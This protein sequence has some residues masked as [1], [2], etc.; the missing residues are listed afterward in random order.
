MSNVRFVYPFDTPPAAE[1]PQ[2]LLGGKGAG[3]S[4]MTQLGIQ[5]PH[6]FTITTEMCSHYYESREHIAES[7][8]QEVL[9][10]IVRLE[11]RMNKRFGD[12]QD[13]LLVSVR[14]GA[15]VSMPGMMDTILNLGLN[16]QTV[17]GLAQ[18]SGNAFF[19]WDSYQRF[20]QMYAHVVLGIKLSA[21]S[22]LYNAEGFSDFGSE[23]YQN[24]HLDETTVSNEPDQVKVIAERVEDMKDEVLQ[25]TGRPFPQDVMEQL[26]GGIEAVLKSWHSERAV[27]YRRHHRYPDDWGTAVNVQAMVFGN[28]GPTSATGVAFTRDPNTGKNTLFGEYLPN[29]QGEDI[30]SGSRTPLP[31]SGS[32]DS[33]EQQMPKVYQELKQLAVRLEAHYKDMQD[34]EFTIERGQLWMLQARSG[35]RS[36][37]A[38]VKIATDMVE[39]GVLSCEQA[40]LRVD[41]AS[42]ESL[43]HP[44]VD[45]QTAPVPW[46]QGLPASPGAAVG[47]IVFSSQEAALAGDTAKEM[48]LVRVETSPEDIAGMIATGGILT[49]CGGMTSHAAVVARGMG[50][51]CVAGCGELHVDHEKQ[52]V[53]G[54]DGVC[55]KAG[56]VITIDGAS[57]HVFRGEVPT[58]AP[59]LGERFEALGRMADRVRR[60]RVRANADTPHDA[61]LACRFGAEGIGLCR[62]E[63][64]FFAKERIDVVREMILSE[65]VQERESALQRILPMQR[66]DFTEILRV[67]GERPVTIRLLDPPLHE[68]LPAKSDLQAIEELA[69]SLRRPLEEVQQRVQRLEEANPMLG[70][71]GC[72]LALTYP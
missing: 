41:P 48:V 58:C 72:R 49:S 19:A 61:Q 24:G 9:S 60:M 59:Q 55:L 7:V 71:R 46:V 36:T 42:I 29:A 69:K 2:H 66:S 12:L 51:P 62:T 22:V 15:R 6:G 45:P 38:A 52:E 20:I 33:L 3:L 65:T 28:M 13:P 10:A 4:Q 50:K 40:L 54:P 63:H 39:E 1:F 23:V 32:D 34:I 18:V 53:R 64:M 11:R 44:T 26:W 14:S 70:H 47:R 30:V 21:D 37:Q 8:R 27:A 67:M 17:E 5:V 57:G 31:L 25:V 68:F 56:D 43:L 35:K 16:D